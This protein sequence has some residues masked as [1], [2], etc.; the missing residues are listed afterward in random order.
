[1]DMTFQVEQWSAETP[2]QREWT[3]TGWTLDPDHRIVRGCVTLE[4]VTIAP[5]SCGRPRPDLATGKSGHEESARCEF[6]AHVLVPA[7]VPSGSHAA[8]IQF[9]DFE[10]T[11]VVSIPLQLSIDTPAAARPSY[12]AA[13]QIGNALPVG[14]LAFM[15]PASDVRESAWIEHIPFAFWVVEHFRPA[16]IVE[17]G[18]HKGASY[19]AFCQAVSELRLESRC[20]GIDTFEGDP[21]ASFYGSEVLDTLRSHHDPL[22]SSFSRLV[23]S[24]FSDALPQ[25][26]DGSIDLL[27]ID[28]AHFYEDVKRDFETWQPKLSQRAV[29]LFHDTRVFSRDFGVHRF[30]AELSRRYPSFEFHHGYGLGVLAVGKDIAPDIAQLVASPDDAAASILQFFSVLGNRLTLA[31]APKPAPVS[32]APPVVSQPHDSDSTVRAL[33]RQQL[34]MQQTCKT[35]IAEAKQVPILR[36]QL[37]EQQ[38]SAA[39]QCR[40]LE[41]VRALSLRGL[42]SRIT[43]SFPWWD[44]MLLRGQRETIERSGLFNARHYVSQLPSGL[45]VKDAL[46]HYLQV[47]RRCGLSPNPLLDASWY[48][49][50]YR[51]SLKGDEPLT[52]FLS[53]G[54]K[55]GRNPHPLFD[56]AWYLQQREGLESSGINPLSDYLENGRALALRPNP[57]FDAAWYVEAH[58]A[59]MTADQT[60]LEHYLLKHAALRSGLMPARNPKAFLPSDAPD[61]TA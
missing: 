9:F 36:K 5:V 56:V 30:W 4:G 23:V 20:H 22:Y 48:A 31:N 24:S 13:L 11:R 16:S 43:A 46:T 21:H 52:D 28:G 54:W 41:R 35:L 58:G 3:L 55:C 45:R 38:R 53:Q 17:L 40:E 25:F 37:K 42:R 8:K 47:G 51:K 57:Q 39:F 26:A 18:V 59:E 7:E 34:V 14:R 2:D 29:V 1:M 33:V 10:G 44:R 60:P 61:Q 12:T 50:T 32:T 49:R 6:R 15:N 19:C 27:H